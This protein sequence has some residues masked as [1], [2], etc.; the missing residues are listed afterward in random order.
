MA[1]I[2]RIYDSYGIARRVADAVNQLGYAEVDA[3]IVGNDAMRTEHETYASDMGNGSLGT[4]RATYAANDGNGIDTVEPASGTATGAGIGAAIGG[5]AGLLAGL[6][7][8][9]IPGIGPVVAAGWLASTAL[10][11]AG[12]AAAGGAV[13]AL[14]DIG[15]PEDDMPVYSE[16][17]RRG[18]MLVSARFPEQHRAAVLAVMDDEPGTPIDQRRRSYEADGWDDRQNEDLPYRVGA[19]PPTM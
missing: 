17:V 9:A 1:V 5:G 14:S 10:G 2:T 11:I 6:G 13:G 16:A 18:G 7:M 19:N 8:L 15:I 4:G 12:G 3:S